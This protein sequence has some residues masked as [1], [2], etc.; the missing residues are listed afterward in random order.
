ME[1]RINSLFKV[2]IFFWE[3]HLVVGTDKEGDL[4]QF[5]SEKKSSTKSNIPLTTTGP[6]R[7]IDT[8][9]YNLS[10]KESH[11][12]TFQQEIHLSK[13]PKSTSYATTSFV[14]HDSRR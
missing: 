1:L 3:Q 8:S 11:I 7:D 9:K 4:M 2:I 12:I 10:D 14:I 5:N 13:S 6:F